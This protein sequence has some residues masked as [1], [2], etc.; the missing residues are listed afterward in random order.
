MLYMAKE[1]KI[2]TDDIEKKLLP[3]V[4]KPARYIG[5]EIN[6]IKKD[7][8]KCDF[9]VA[10]CFPDI[11]EIAMSHTGLAIIYHVLNEQKTI[12]AERAF[13][14]WTDAED[15]MRQKD[16][17]MFTLESKASVADF[18]IVG[19]SLTNELCCTNMLNMLDLA[20]IPIRTSDRNENHPLVIA[21]GQSANC[22]EP[23]ADFVDIF[24]LGEA[25]YAIIELVKLL[26]NQRRKNATRKQTLFEVAKNLSFAYVPSLYAF[27]YEGDK[28]KSLKPT[29]SNLP[30]R[31][32]NAV[33]QD[34]DASPVPP[35]P[36]VPFVQ[37]VHERISVEIMRGCPG[38]CRF[39]QASFCRRPLRFRSPER[40]FEIAKQNYHATGL[41]T[42]GLLSL[43]S[44]DYPHLEKLVEKLQ[45]YFT[46]L[47]VGI[48]LPSL[49]VQAQLKLLPKLVSSVRKSG[50]TIAI[51]AATETLRKI[52][53]KPITDDD[54]LAGIGAAFEAGFGKVKLYFMVGLPGETEDDIKQ[55]VHLSNRIALLRK[56]IA[57]KIASVNITI[58]FLVPKPHTPLQ[59][60]GQKS[61]DYFHNA[62][63]LILNEKK[64]LNARSLQFKFH[65][66]ETSIL[67]SAIARGDRR[68]C[69]VIECA[70][71]LGAKFDLWTE[72]FN[73]RIWQ[74][75]FAENNLDLE[76]EAAKAFSPDDMLP[77]DHLGGPKK[78]T[79]IKHYNDAGICY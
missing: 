63:S 57:R 56:Q 50:L 35:A 55:I 74:R 38:R 3:F 6:Q 4:R 36:I 39:C 72:C 30:V 18:D 61:K 15:I 26:Q 59:W 77:W 68:L 5:G 24:I 46:P 76:D 28:I 64:H 44:A 19:F 79:L 37:P 49:K 62:R 20:K 27:E 71:R 25:E 52:I 43:S 33:V 47:H 34:L 8:T 16:I 70:F 11:Y 31:F 23:I 48:S 9:T 45:H 65:H 10:L 54:L 13:A 1:I 69:K 66:I 60:V 78:Q 22:A 14:P 67:E 17:P 12:A 29:V 58:S 32:E 2:L 41:D 51:E 73:Y 75:A 40:V 53:N 21:G 7:L 42:V